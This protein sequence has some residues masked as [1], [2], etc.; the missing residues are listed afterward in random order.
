MY[1]IRS[2]YE[3]SDSHLILK[4]ASGN[5]IFEHERASKGQFS[6]DSKFLA[7][8]IKP[9]KDS[10]NDMQ[11][12]KGKKD[13]LPKDS[14]GIYYVDTKELIKLPNLKSFSLP[15]KWSG[16]L[17]YYSEEFKESYNFV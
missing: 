9:W 8:I 3:N 1:A 6:Y 12:R 10:V 15:E 5:T 16:Y 17:A 13:K 4:D 2:Y 14:L 11:R 7:F